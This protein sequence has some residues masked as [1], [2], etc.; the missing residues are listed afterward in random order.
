MMAEGLRGLYQVM[1][2]LDGK[3]AGE[4]RSL[5]CSN[6]LACVALTVL[7]EVTGGDLT[8]MLLLVIHSHGLDREQV[9]LLDSYMAAQRGKLQ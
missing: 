4:P 7:D 1:R 3:A 8:R 9:N 5:E 2:R 6:A